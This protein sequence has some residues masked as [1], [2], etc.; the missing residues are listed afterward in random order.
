[1]LQKPIA[2]SLAGIDTLWLVIILVLVM[3]II[4]VVRK[5]LEGLVDIAVHGISRWLSEK[6]KEKVLATKEI[7]SSIRIEQ[8]ENERRAEVT[9]E[10]GEERT[11]LVKGLIY[12]IGA[13][14]FIIVIGPALLV[15]LIPIKGMLLISIMYKVLGALIVALMIAGIIFPSGRKENDRN[16]WIKYLIHAV[17]LCMGIMMLV[18]SK[19]Y[20]DMY[21]NRKELGKIEKRLG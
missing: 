5:F 16:G 21:E 4:P 11:E 8:V 6:E 17:L 12:I 15:Y 9:V 18:E 1:M 20:G 10:H 2:E 13:F 19:Y 3:V 14:I 7:K